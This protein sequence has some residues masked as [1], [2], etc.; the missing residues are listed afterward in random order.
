MGPHRGS[1]LRWPFFISVSEK[2]R[3]RNS[4]VMSGRL[5][6]IDDVLERLPGVTE[7]K[8]RER[9]RKLG[10][11]RQ[12]GNTLLLTEGDFRNLLE[13]AAP[14]SN[15]PNAEDTNTSGAPSEVNRSTRLRKLRAGNSPTQSGLGGKR[16][17]SN[18]VSM[19]P[20]RR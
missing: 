6:T 8:L 4:W 15:S 19:A 3:Q 13:E 20:P 11:Y 1:A 2:Y 10:R 7:R 18:V 5:L 12:F 9:I 14:C 17:S 16:K